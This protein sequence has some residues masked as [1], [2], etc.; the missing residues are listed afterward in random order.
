MTSVTSSAATRIARTIARSTARVAAEAAP[1]ELHRP[2]SAG[3]GA[4]RFVG[5]AGHRVRITRLPRKEH[6]GVGQGTFA[7]RTPQQHIQWQ[8]GGLAKDVPQ[9][10]LDAAHRRSR[11]AS[12]G[13]DIRPADSSLWTTRSTSRGSSPTADARSP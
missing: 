3:Y 9:G 7:M 13:A 8:A 1:T 2:E 12:A 11:G 6:T 10:H 5:H 4:R